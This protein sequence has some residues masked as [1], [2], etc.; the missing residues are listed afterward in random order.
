MP[1]PIHL[2]IPSDDCGKTRE[3]Y[4][5]A[6][7]WEFQ[8]WDGPQEYWL[9]RTGPE[10]APGIDGGMGPRRPGS[11]LTATLDVPD[12]DDYVG[13]VERAGG[14]IVMPRMAIP[15]VGWLAYFS[16]TDGNVLGMMQADPGAA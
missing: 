6:F 1:R 3:F 11:A 10:G 5:T 13:R 9:V 8:K 14:T 2:E 4:S 7:G 12:L 16:D 15:G